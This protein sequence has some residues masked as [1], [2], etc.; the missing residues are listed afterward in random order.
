MEAPIR[1]EI[2]HAVRA[3]L[4]SFLTDLLRALPRAESCEAASGEIASFLAEVP[5]GEY[6]ASDLYD[7]FVAWK[8]TQPWSGNVPTITWFGR[9]VARDP[10]VARLRR[11]AGRRYV[12]RGA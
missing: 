4:T 11:P 12:V 3:E 8:D 5:S 7:R 9:H 1:D 6:A 10:R 2:R